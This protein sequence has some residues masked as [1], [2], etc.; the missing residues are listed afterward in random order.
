M[1]EGIFS[2]R[3]GAAAGAAGALAPVLPENYKRIG[4]NLCLKL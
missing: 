1:K 4:F 2:I 3:G